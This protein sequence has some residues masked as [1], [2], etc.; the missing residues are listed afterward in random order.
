[1]E[2][3]WA[4]WRVN[5]IKVAAKDRKGC[6]FCELPGG[7]DEENLILFRGERAYILMNRFPYNPGHLMVAPYRHV[8]SPRDLG[9]EEAWEIFSLVRASIGA[10]ESVMEP[11]GFNLGMNLGRIAGAGFEGHLHVHVV[12]RWSGDTNFMPVIADTKVVSESLESTYRSLKPEITERAEQ[13]LKRGDGARRGG[14]VG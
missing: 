9:W 14:A 7:N 6:I 5:Y 11:H 12:P 4:T 3:L 10:L 13:I 1:M 2:R 8:A